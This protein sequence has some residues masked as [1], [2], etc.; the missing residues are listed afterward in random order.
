V[1]GLERNLNKKVI[2]G[3]IITAAIATT[4]II[5]AVIILQPQLKKMLLLTQ[6]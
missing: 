3:I 4:G 1:R 2:I 5:T 6:E